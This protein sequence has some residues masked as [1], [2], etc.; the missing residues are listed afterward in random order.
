[1]RLPSFGSGHQCPRWLHRPRLRRLR[2]RWSWLRRSR[3]RRPRLLRPRLRLLWPRLRL[4]PWLWLRSRLWLW[5]RLRPWSGLW[6][7]CPNWLRCRCSSCHQGLYCPPRPSRCLLRRRPS[8]HLRCCPSCCQGVYRPSCPSRCLLRRC[9]GRHLRCCSGR[10]LRCC[11]SCDQGLYCPPCPSCCLLRRRSS[12]LLRCSPSC[13]QGCHRLPR[14][15]SHHHRCSRSILRLRLWRWPPRI[16]SRTLRLRTWSIQLR[17]ELRLWSWHL[18]RLRYPPPQE[19][20]NCRMKTRIH[21]GPRGTTLH[22]PGFFSCAVCLM[23]CE[24]RI[25]YIHCHVPI[26]LLFGDV[27][28][29]QFLVISISNYF[30]L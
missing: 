22:P 27:Q 23:E 8:S 10:H 3:L 9:S 15:S 18:R 12:R 6:T 7:L 24:F 26:F 19:E 13:H 14:C 5:P 11:S 4:R 1:P 29:G 21:N 16:R 28:Y 20:V 17:P 2:L 30:W 25:N